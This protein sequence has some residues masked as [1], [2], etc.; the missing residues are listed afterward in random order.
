MEVNIIHII[1]SSLV[2]IGGLT[3][4]LFSFKK[5]KRF[6]NLKHCQISH[7]WKNI[8]DIAWIKASYL[9][10]INGVQ[11]KTKCIDIIIEKGIKI[12]P[13]TNQW[14][15]PT[16][17]NG[18]EF[19][20]AGLTSPTCIKIVADSNGKPYSRTQAIFSHECGESI[21]YTN[22]KW[23]TKSIDERNNFLW[24]IGL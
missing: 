20:Y 23:A 21:L 13:Q 2:M 6:N 11:A 16:M 15:R 7:E 1:V 14:G 22:K 3:A 17:L 9:L 10:S 5:D 12:N 24:S 18:K 8:R 19:W 4:S